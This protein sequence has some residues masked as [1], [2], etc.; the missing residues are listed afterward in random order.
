MC[1]YGL[2]GDV[3]PTKKGRQFILDS[4]TSLK[5]GAHNKGPNVTVL[6]FCLIRLPLQIL[7]NVSLNNTD[8]PL[9]GAW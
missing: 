8:L 7:Y 1:Q 9:P 3:G 2:A 4:N 5:V 6:C